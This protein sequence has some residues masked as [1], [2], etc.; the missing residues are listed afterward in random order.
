MTKLKMPEFVYHVIGYPQGAGPFGGEF[1]ILTTYN[2]KEAKKAYKEDEDAVRFLKIKLPPL[3]HHK[4][5]TG[6]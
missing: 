1:T 4:T 5:K 2:E 6:N 3:M